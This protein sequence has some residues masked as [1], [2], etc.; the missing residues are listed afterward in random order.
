MDH[1]IN[2]RVHRELSART[3]TYPSTIPVSDG[4]TSDFA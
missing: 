1:K 4:L 3:V 2:C